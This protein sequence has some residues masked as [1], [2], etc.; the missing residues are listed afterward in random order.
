MSQPRRWQRS[1]HQRFEA[2]PLE[3]VRRPAVSALPLG[4]PSSTGHMRRQVATLYVPGADNP[5]LQVF[6]KALIHTY[7]TNVLMDVT[8]NQRSSSRSSPFLFRHDLRSAPS[9]KPPGLLSS[10]E[11]LPAFLV[12]CS[13][14]RMRSMACRFFFITSGA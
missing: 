10:T 9:S 7:Y 4:R 11:S 12:G 14:A 8:G 13:A 1:A 2:T 3:A 5:L 6:V